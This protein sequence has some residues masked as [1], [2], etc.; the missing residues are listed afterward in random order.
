MDAYPAISFNLAVGEQVDFIDVDLEGIAQRLRSKGMT[1]ESIQNLSVVFTGNASHDDTERYVTK[2]EYESKRH[3]IQVYA[4]A[5]MND[6]VFT[7]TEQ[8]EGRI[9]LNN[10]AAIEYSLN[11][12]LVHE[13]EHAALSGDEEMKTKNSNYY[14]T[15]ARQFEEAHKPLYRKKMGA[16]AVMGLVA[17][18]ISFSDAMIENA[19][20]QHI[21]DML[22]YAV[23][24]GG[25]I[26]LVAMKRHLKQ[27]FAKV[28]H[29]YYLNEPEEKQARA[30]STENTDQYV[31]ITP[32]V[33]AIAP[34]A[35][36]DVLEAVDIWSEANGPSIAPGV[37]LS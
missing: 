31:S 7:I 28:K 10:A 34:E 16:I 17:N 1:D 6:C 22:P 35:L 37:A 20:V 33:L 21:C 4:P 8:S 11:N 14:E 23:I 30:A 36:G 15:I 3:R 18:A 24:G 13:L 32:K 27:N 25:V 19:T 2:G 5:P 29:R 12:T 26:S 9:R